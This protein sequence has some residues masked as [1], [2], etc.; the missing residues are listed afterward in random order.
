MIEE[1][2]S[3]MD[4]LWSVVNRAHGQDSYAVQEARNQLLQRYG[5]AVRKYLL[6]ALRQ[7]TDASEVYQ[8]FALRVIRGD[9]HR[10][11]P[12]QGQFRKYLK[13]SLFRLI[14]DFQRKRGT[15]ELQLDVWDGVL[16]GQDLDSQ[17][18]MFTRKW[19]TELID[20][21]MERL[22]DVDVQSGTHLY[23]VLHLRISH[24][25]L[26]S[27][28]LGQLASQKLGK[29][30]SADNFRAIL[31]RAR[32]RFAHLLIDE[33]CQTLDHPKRDD[34]ETELGEL[35]LLEYCKPA[36]GEATG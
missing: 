14:V 7:E 1:R 20:R 35:N 11:S 22:R 26:R 34:L 27:Q 36:L 24:P 30:I 2:L 4:T 15:R 25:N 9:F 33:V 21:V 5:V 12:A 29:S 10:A 19:R 31:K 17:H 3:Q 23:P 6:A 32:T 8:E 16:T 13:T 28:S 18:A